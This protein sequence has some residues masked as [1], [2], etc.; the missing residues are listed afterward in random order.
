MIVSDPRELPELEVVR[1]A[2][3]E[4]ATSEFRGFQKRTINFHSEALPRDTEIAGHMR[5]VLACAADAPDF[6]LWAQVLMVQADGTV[7]RLGEDIRRARFRNSPF[8]Q[9]LL[10]PGELVKIPFEFNWT[11]WRIPKGARLRLSIAP[12]NSPNFQKNFNTGGPV[13]HEQLQ[14]ARVASIKIFHDA[15]HAS[16]LELPLAASLPTN[17]H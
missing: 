10:K 17:A 12:L 13:G 8:K 4:D 3:A 7:V 5:L 2:E 1:F 15:Q 11:A 6:D 9:Q 16:R 14:D